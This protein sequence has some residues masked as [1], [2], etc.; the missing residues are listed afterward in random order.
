MTIA[1]NRGVFQFSKSN[2]QTL[3]MQTF[4]N[5][6]YFTV[7]TLLLFGTVI[8]LV[9]LIIYPC[10][11]QIYCCEKQNCKHG[12]ELYLVKHVKNV[13]VF[14][15]VCELAGKLVK[16]SNLQACYYYFRT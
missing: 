3:P 15:R 5:V 1:N 11:V 8:L 16:S 9:F 14:N 12:A 6:S 7:L 4:L 2:K 13:M 10:F